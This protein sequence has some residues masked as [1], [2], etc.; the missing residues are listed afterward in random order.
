MKE[1]FFKALEEFKKWFLN[2]WR[3]AKVF[4]DALAKRLDYAV[5]RVRIGKKKIIQNIDKIKDY[6][7]TVHSCAEYLD[8]GQECTSESYING[9]ANQLINLEWLQAPPSRENYNNLV[10]VSS[11]IAAASKRLDAKHKITIDDLD[12]GIDDL[13]NSIDRASQEIMDLTLKFDK[14]DTMFKNAP[15]V[16]VPDEG[17]IS[18]EAMYAAV[19]VCTREAINFRIKSITLDAQDAITACSNMLSIIDG[20]GIKE[21]ALLDLALTQQIQSEYALIEACMI[22]DNGGV[23]SSALDEGFFDTLKVG[24]RKLMEILKALLTKFMSGVNKITD[25]IRNFASN[26]LYFV[27]SNEKQILRYYNTYL[28]NY[29]FKIRKPT[30]LAD[31]I[32]KYLESISPNQFMAKDFPPDDGGTP[33]SKKDDEQQQM[34]A[35]ANSAILMESTYFS[36]AELKLIKAAADSKLDDWVVVEKTTLKDIGGAKAVIDILKRT[37]TFSDGD[38]YLSYMRKINKIAEKEMKLI[39]A[40]IARYNAKA[41]KQGYTDESM[42]EES[43]VIRKQI[44]YYRMQNVVLS[45]MTVMLVEN[46][47][48]YIAVLHKL[49]EESHDESADIST[50]SAYDRL[51]AE[52]E[53]IKAQRLCTV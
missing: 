42:D 20:K 10:R 33:G 30:K 12:N 19:L 9:L 26:E 21:T 28:P 46:V 25:A 6:E 52:A 18:P 14:I 40:K 17:E 7:F 35:L 34:V 8:D 50:G 48:A 41:D 5:K 36:D 3:K 1:K 15:K 49:I 4:F 53:R 38:N 2:L 29:E 24:W 16:V 45:S 13:L 11:V 32:K 37:F 22:E 27:R 47:K 51:L 43:K 31:D 23:N 44:A 39:N